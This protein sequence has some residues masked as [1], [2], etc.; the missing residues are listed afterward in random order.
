M[1]ALPATALSLALAMATWTMPGWTVPAAARPAAP[2]TPP[3]CGQQVGAFRFALND[4]MRGRSIEPSVYATI[5]AELGPIADACRRGDEAQAGRLLRA[6][7]RRW[8][9]Q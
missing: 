3:V 5:L 9:F 8:R 7:K 6:L 1:I 2:A 4:E